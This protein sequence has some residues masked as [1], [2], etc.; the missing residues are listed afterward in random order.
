LRTLSFNVTS[1]DKIGSL[2]VMHFCRTAPLFAIL[3]ALLAENSPAQKKKPGSDDEGY[4]PVVAPET[5][6]KKN[7]EDTQT[8]PPAKEL[9]GR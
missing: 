6:Q 7:K 4:V 2:A 9:P 5:K 8:L 1:F 3:I